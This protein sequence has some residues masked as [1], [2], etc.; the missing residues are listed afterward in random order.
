M[1][2]MR[3]SCAGGFPEAA[4]WNPDS[5]GYVLEFSDLTGDQRCGALVSRGCGNGAL[6]VCFTPAVGVGGASSLPYRLIN[7]PW[8]IVQEHAKEA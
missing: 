2:Q 3:F 4:P 7:S 1:R 6:L 8:G 5:S